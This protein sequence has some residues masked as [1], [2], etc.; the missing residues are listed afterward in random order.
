MTK[1]FSVVYEV[2]PDKANEAVFET[3]KTASAIDKELLPGIR[4]TACG[5]GDYATQ[6]AAFQAETD[7]DGKSTE[8]ILQVFLEPENPGLSP[9]DLLAKAK[10]VLGE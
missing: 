2:D 4:I 6:A 10:A 9:D 5:W 8:E 1:Y 3:F 7:N